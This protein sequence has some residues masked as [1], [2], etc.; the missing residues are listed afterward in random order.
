MLKHI[1]LTVLLISLLAACGGPSREPLAV[2]LQAKEMTFDLTTIEAGVNQ[3]I[4]LTYVNE[5]LIDHAF[6]VE[7]LVEEQKVKSGETRSFTFTP[8]RVGAFKYYCT[9][10]GHEMAGMTGTLTVIP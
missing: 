2:T 3:P 1:L 7:G 9:I 8:T 4:T 10:P 5:G 6:A